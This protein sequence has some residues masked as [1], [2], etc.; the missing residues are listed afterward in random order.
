MLA[1]SFGRPVVSI[2]AGFLRDVVNEDTGVLY[3]ADSRQALLQALQTVLSRPFDERTIRANARLYTYD[4]AAEA[5]LGA[6]GV[7]AAPD[8][9]TQISRCR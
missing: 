4:H 8:G 5:F 3:S 7:V 9:A 1:L 6:I 2:D